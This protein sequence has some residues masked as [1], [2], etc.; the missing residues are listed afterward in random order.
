MSTDTEKRLKRLDRLT[1]IGGGVAFLMLLFRNGFPGLTIPQPILLAW[2]A[3]L[4]VGLFLE[5]FFRLLWVPDPWRYLRTHPMRY[6]VLLM[7]VLELSG[8]AAWQQSRQA[9]SADISLVVAELYIAISMLA[10]IGSW[11][12]GGLAANRWLA[13]RRIPLLVIPVLSFAAVILVGAAILALPG[14]HRQPLAA[15]DLLF[16]ATS[17]VCV[18]GL[19]VFDLATAFTPVGQTVVVLLI[20]FGGLG[21]M[22]MLGLLALWHGGRLSFGERVLLKELVGGQQLAETR[23]LL[24]T[25]ARVT[26]MVEILGALTLGFLWRNRVPHAMLQG[27]FHSISA[28]CN[29]GFTLFQDGFLSFRQDRLTLLVIMALVFVGGLGFT[30]VAD[31][32]RTGLSRLL[33]WIPVQPLRKATRIVLAW[34]SGLILVGAL[35][36]WLDGFLY[37]QPRTVFSAFF[38]SI[39]CRTA[40]FQ[41]ESQ[42]HFGALGFYAALILMAIGASPQS[43]G[44]G[45]RTTVLARLF[46]KIDPV[47]MDEEPKK[48]ILFKPF[49]VALF[50]AVCYIGIAASAALLLLVFEPFPWKDLFYESFSA[51]G[52][53]GLSRDITTLLSSAGKLC[54]IVLMFIG[55]VLYPILVIRMIRG[56]RPGP[57]PVEWV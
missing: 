24:L 31:L 5:A 49:R 38:Q 9:R 39:A 52:T 37:G 21:A 29:A 41:I 48:L 13:N 3:L 16:T 34:S 57:D 44:G 33:P 10:F 22:T 55:R 35:A 28:F 8:V 2:A 11:M 36:F 12:K 14:F 45:M 27:A 20:Q 7:I 23:R 56:R 30:V 43:T 54:M 50:C 19:T 18:T 15:L 26:L 25:I 47:D 53:V 32:S 51:L 6:I 46:Y 1:A 42:L 17:A 40:G 4:P